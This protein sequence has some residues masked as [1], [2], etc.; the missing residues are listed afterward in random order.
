M[1][2]TVIEQIKDRLPIAEVLSGY[3][4]LIPA[5][6]QF[7]ARCPFHNEKT[8]SFSVSPASGFYY[9]FG[10][11]AKGDIFSFVEKFEGL[12][13]K[14][15]L[16][17]LAERA[18]VE[19][20]YEKQDATGPDG[21]AFLETIT[22]KYQQSLQ[23]HPEA[24]A[25]LAS[26]GITSET[27]TN[28]R[29][30]YAPDEWQ[31]IAQ[32]LISSD[33]KKLAQE[34]GIAK[35][36]E[37]DG[38]TRLYDRFR[39]RIMFPLCDSSGRV[40]GFS[41]RIF[42]NSDTGPKYL[43]SPE[44]SLFHK[45]KVLYG[46]DKAKAAI[47]KHN[48]AILVEGQMDMVV[49]HQ[50]GFKNTIATSGTAVSN[51]SA[52]DVFSHLAI[53]S[54]LVP[55][56]ILAFDGDSAGIKAQHKAA[57]VA[58]SLGMNPKVV[59]IPEGSDPADFLLAQGTQGW[60]DLLAQSTTYIQA[61]LGR[62]PLNS[63][64][65]A[66]PRMLQAE[67]F[68]ALAVVKSHIEQSQYIQMISKE[69][70]LKES[71]VQSDF[72]NFL[73]N[74]TPENTTSEQTPQIDKKIVAPGLFIQF[75]ALSNFVQ[76]EAITKLYEQLCGYSFEDTHIVVPEYSDT[77]LEYAHAYVEREYGHLEMKDFILLAQDF[78]KNITHTFL[79]EL[80][81]TLTIQLSQ[82]EKIGAH[83]DVEILV[84]KLHAITLRQHEI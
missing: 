68:P 24:L 52:K 57:L 37:K 55:N 58:Y 75:A 36:V 15:T 23:N 17:L 63:S 29:I 80:K 21:Y 40:I 43:N 13:F 12:D 74:H 38:Q 50:Y 82:K 46:F 44:T 53:I 59:T 45:S 81:Q 65:A 20:V 35:Q 60:K 19:L 70:S 22:T 28:F 2:R 61:A 54:R 18:G 39:S 25:Y 4:T 32:T 69:L 34:M 78:Y 47:K 11:G 64:A 71:A 1:S 79:E 14:G 30:G 49:S 10:C 67:V 27:I 33:D 77:E 84:K 76:N 73:Q 66:L 62:I 42:P 31:Y 5:G 83:D 41:G 9:C 26:R 7:K 6:T 48:F 3:I 8:P 72:E 16:K 51:E 56:I